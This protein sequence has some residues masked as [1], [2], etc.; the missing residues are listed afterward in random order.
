MGL[1]DAFFGL[2]AVLLLAVPQSARAQM[3]LEPA[4]SGRPMVG[5]K[6]SAGAVIWSHGRS[7]DSEDA[8]VATPPYMAAL[9]EAGWDA[10]RFNRMRA[11]DSLTSSPRG[12]VDEVHRLKQQG[13]RKVI[14]AGQSFGAFVALIAADISDEIDAVIVTAPAAFG[15]VT[16]LA[17]R[18]RENATRLYPLLEQVRHARVMVFYFDDDEYDPGGR[19]ETTNAILAARGLPHLVIDRPAGLRTHWAATTPAFATRYAGCMLDFVAAAAVDN[20]ASCAGGLPT[21]AQRAA[22]ATGFAGG[23]ILISR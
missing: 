21:E 22:A 1:R 3:W 15:S 18:W 17:G 11:S 14:L 16:D 12:L 20:H 4:V 5:P 9:R 8:I 7:V 6:H 13:Y 10:F 19:G 23:N 2:A